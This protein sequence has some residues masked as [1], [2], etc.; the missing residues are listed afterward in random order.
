MLPYAAVCANPTAA[1]QRQID[2]FPYRQG[3]GCVEQMTNNPRKHNGKSLCSCQCHLAI[4]LLFKGD[5]DK[6]H[7][8]TA[9]QRKRDN[10]RNVRDS[11]QITEETL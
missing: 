3:A 7:V 4:V 2:S 11:T 1:T 8:S 5:G 9:E 6:Q 10:G